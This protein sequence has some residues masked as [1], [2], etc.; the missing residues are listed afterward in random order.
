MVD[1]RLLTSE[2]EQ[3]VRGVLAQEFD[4][5]FSKQ[6][7]P[8]RTGGQHEF[9]AAA[10]DRTIIASIKS[11]SGR[12]ASGKYPAGKVSS[13]IAE[14]YF[15]TLVAAPRRLLVLTTPEFYTIFTK[16]LEGKIADGIDVRMIPLPETLQLKVAEVQG[17]ASLEVTPVLDPDEQEI[18]RTIE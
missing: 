15:L 5:P 7:L 10:A 11:S 6:V 12:T 18:V 4:R 13:A 16:A 8:L 9:D 1:T 3:H 14:L 2:V 17:L